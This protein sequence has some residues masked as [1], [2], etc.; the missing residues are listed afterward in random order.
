MMLFYA[1]EKGIQTNKTSTIKVFPR[2]IV[3]QK[4]FE[5]VFQL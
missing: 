5:P 4:V 3:V 2:L 1:K